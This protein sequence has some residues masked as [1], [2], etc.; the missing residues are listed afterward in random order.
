MQEIIKA[1]RPFQRYELPRTEGMAKLQQEGDWCEEHNRPESQCFLCRP[2]AEA[3]FA[4]VYTA[5][6]GEQ[7]PKPTE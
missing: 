2:D 5:K 4:A 7:P 3:K 1:D 6:F